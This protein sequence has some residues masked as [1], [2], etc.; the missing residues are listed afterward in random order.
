MIPSSFY[1]QKSSNFQLF[2]DGALGWNGVDFVRG[3]N[4]RH[5]ERSFCCFGLLFCGF[6]LQA[7]RFSLG[8]FVMVVKE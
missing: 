4:W 3:H 1:R 7:F 6:V 8:T 5:T 2:V